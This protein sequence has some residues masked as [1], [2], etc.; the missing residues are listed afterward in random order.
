MSN[1]VKATL[2]AIVGFLAGASILFIALVA[3]VGYAWMTKTEVIIPGV[4]KAFFTTENDLPALNFEPN[5]IGMLVIVL[6][7]A[8]L[9]VI[10]SLRG[11][12]KRTP[13]V[14]T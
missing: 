3:C 14:S 8:A 2:G 4:F 5:G 6:V 10:G 1:F 9:S 13:Q 11:P 7:I 12:R